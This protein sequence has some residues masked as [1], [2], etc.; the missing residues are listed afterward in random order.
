MRFYRGGMTWR[1]C[2]SGR[3]T[4]RLNSS[5]G[6]LDFCRLLSDQKPGTT[7]H[8]GVKL[9]TNDRNLECRSINILVQCIC[10]KIHFWQYWKEVSFSNRIFDKRF[11][12]NLCMLHCTAFFMIKV[13]CLVLSF[14][15]SNYFVCPLMWYGKFTTGLHTPLISETFGMTLWLITLCQKTNWP[16]SL[17]RRSGQKN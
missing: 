12:V 17:L 5:P 10:Y 3:S 4:C 7:E 13:Y 2:Q 14:T 1:N 16:Q 15:L 11:S 6:S 8:R 9:H